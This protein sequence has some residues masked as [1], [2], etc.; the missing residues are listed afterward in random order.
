MV[1]LVL[2]NQWRQTSLSLAERFNFT[3]V[4]EPPVEGYYLV[5]EDGVLNVRKLEWGPRFSIH[6]DLPKEVNRIQ[7]QRQGFKKDILCRSLGYKGQENF[8]VIDGTLG[9]GKDALHIIS[10]GI[11]VLGFEINPI[12]FCLVEEALVRASHKF[13]VSD[14]RP[15]VVTEET[16]PD[17]SVDLKKFLKI[18]LMDCFKG[19]S[20]FSEGVQSLYLDPMFENTKNKSKPKKS[21]TFL[22]DITHETCDVQRVITQALN[23]GIKRVVVKRPI[24]GDY[25][26]GKPDFLYKG[27]L[28]VQKLVYD[29]YI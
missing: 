25:L 4:W 21:M 3:R 1:V 17:H 26:N 13:S 24:N 14:T 16:A 6:L 11:H 15:L 9:L 18:R 8:K 5:V 10:F 20:L 22:R 28:L 23:R 2:D 7:R 12:P 27:K 29:V 19:V